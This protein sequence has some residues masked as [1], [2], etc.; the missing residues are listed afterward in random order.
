MG[1]DGSN[2]HNGNGGGR[3]IIPK[4][5]DETDPVRVLDFEK[6]QWWGKIGVFHDEIKRMEAAGYTS[7]VLREDGEGKPTAVRLTPPWWKV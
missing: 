1:G 6:R 2:G 3:P 5:H 4:H 7:E